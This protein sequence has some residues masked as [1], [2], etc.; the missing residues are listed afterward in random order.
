MKYPLRMIRQVALDHRFAI[1]DADHKI[2]FRIMDEDERSIDLALFVV[3]IANRFCRLR[4]WFKP[5]TRDD[6]IWAKSP[7]GSEVGHDHAQ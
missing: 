4:L 1:A 7:I 5:F 2:I 3:K 6:W